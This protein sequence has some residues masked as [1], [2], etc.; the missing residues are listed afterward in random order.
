LSLEFAR[1]ESGK[2]KG[3]STATTIELR[4]R[5]YAT[6]T[7][8]ADGLMNLI[9]AQASAARVESP[10]RLSL[11]SAFK[12]GFS[13]VYDVLNESE[14]DEVKMGQLLCEAQPNASETI[15]GYEAYAGDATS[16]LRDNA[17]T[18]ADRTMQKSDA[19]SAGVAGHKYQWLARLVT[20]RKS[21][22]AP[23]AV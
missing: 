18:L 3:M 13:S 4:K 1:K 7:Q 8:R 19:R 9:D 23:Q 12:R 15:G 22:V 21:W 11:S 10:V 5:L 20:E 17:K 6:F 14:I 2:L 16:E